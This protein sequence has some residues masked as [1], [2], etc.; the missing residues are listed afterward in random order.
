MNDRQNFPRIFDEASMD[1]LPEFSFQRCFPWAVPAAAGLAILIMIAITV[2]QPRHD[3]NSEFVSP[4]QE[5]EILK[6]Q[7]RIERDNNAALI[8]QVHKQLKQSTD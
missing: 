2:F 5:V 6:W 1:R 8:E 7:L 4:E 3:R